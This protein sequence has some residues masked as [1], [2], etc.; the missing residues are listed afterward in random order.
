MLSLAKTWLDACE[1]GEDDHFVDCQNPFKEAAPERVLLVAH[2][3][4]TRHIQL[5][6]LE[7]SGDDFPLYA[8]LSYCWGQR[9]SLMLTAGA[10]E[11]V[12][13]E[14]LNLDDLPATIRDA[15]EVCDGI[16]IP[17]LFV[18]SLCI[19]Q[20]RSRLGRSLKAHGRHL[21]LGHAHHRCGL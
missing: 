10:L 5:V 4:A 19:L 18:D 8:C 14:G 17:Y 15:C 11:A 6:K 21:F 7:D 1:S 13:N 16:G 9:Q 12:L 20:L 2:C 3:H